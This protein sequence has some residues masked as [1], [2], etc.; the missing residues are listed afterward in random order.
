M[1]EEAYNERKDW[2]QAVAFGLVRP[3]LHPLG[4]AHPCCEPFS[5][6]IAETPTVRSL[7]DYNW[8]VAHSDACLVSD[9]TVMD[10]I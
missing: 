9:Q 5:I 2:R 6:L 1:V 4:P 10:G 3:W 8:P 7:I